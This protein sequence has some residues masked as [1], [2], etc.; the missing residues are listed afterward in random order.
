MLL[1]RGSLI[2]AISW[3]SGNES[4]ALKIA[5]E[6]FFSFGMFSIV[7]NTSNDIRCEIFM[8]VSSLH[9]QRVFLL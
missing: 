3:R 4:P 2:N 9:D 7:F 8:L 5:F 6:A 1:L